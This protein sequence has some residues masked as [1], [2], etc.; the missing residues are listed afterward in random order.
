MFTD[1]H[2]WIIVGFLAISIVALNWLST[3][4]Y[5]TEL[6]SIL[7]N[8]DKIREM[9]VQIRDL[10]V[11]RDGNRHELDSRGPRLDVLE[12]KVKA[13]EEK[14]SKPPPVAGQQ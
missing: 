9:Q 4:R 10:E 5:S 12:R 2:T 14:A 8:Q 11:S 7:A 6:K 3:P 13:L 1:W